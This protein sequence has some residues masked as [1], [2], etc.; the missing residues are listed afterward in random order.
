MIKN[1]EFTNSKGEKIKGILKE[2]NTSGPLLIVGHGLNSSKEHP[3]SEGITD[4]L[5]TMGHSSFS[6]DFSKSAQNFSL[7]EQVSDILDIINHFSNY[8]EN[9]LLAPS[10]GVLSMVITAKQSEKVTGLITIN[11]FFGTAQLG[12]EIL[13]TYLLFRVLV[14]INKRYKENWKYFKQQYKPKKINC[15]TLVIHARHDEVVFISQSNSFFRKL[16]GKKEFHILE[17]G[18]HNLTQESTKQETADVI[19]RWLKKWF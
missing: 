2:K 18:D 5:Y 8:K 15:K 19:D 13:K 17:K 3:A 14:F 11:G 16:G 10:L 9:V 7:K 4:R 1:L 6:F 12:L